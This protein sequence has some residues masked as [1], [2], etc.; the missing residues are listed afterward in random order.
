MMDRTRLAFAEANIPR[1]TSYP[2]AAQFKPNICN[3]TYGDWLRAIEPGERLSLYIHIPFCQSL[4][5]YCGCHTTVP[6]D[7]QRVTRYLKRLHREIDLVA[8]EVTGDAQVAHF[9]MGGGTPSYLRPVD[10]SALI[11]H[12]TKRFN[13]EPGAELAIELDPRTLTPEFVETL[14]ESGINRASLG[15]QEFDAEV[16]QRIHRVQPYEQVVDAVNNLR[17]AGIS[18]INFDLMYGLPG[19]SLQNIENSARLA[20]GLDPDRLAVFGYAHVPWFKKNQR[21]IDEA[22]LPDTEERLA[23]AECAAASLQAAGYRRIGFDHFAKPTDALAKALENGTLRRNFQ[24]YTDDTDST[25][26]GFGASAIGCLS[27][28]YVQNQ[29]HIGLYNEVIREGELATCRGVAVSSEDRV[30]R[31]AIEK[32]MCFLSLDTKAL[33]REFGLPDTHFDAAFEKL[34]PLAAA[35]LVEISGRRVTIPDRHR[36]FMRNAAACFDAYLV[37]APQRH[38]RA[39]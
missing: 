10:F 39:V 14:K 11:S 35:G 3:D 27:Q 26:L 15:V 37:E 5:W 23:Q 24:G 19:Q 33:I 32:L 38:S 13:F 20:A 21:A 36:A 22:L 2:T 7:Y 8:N 6:N 34:A 25:V 30:R 29:P 31:L 1:Y 17:A 16:Q 4:C 9:H 12:L 28:G 18:A